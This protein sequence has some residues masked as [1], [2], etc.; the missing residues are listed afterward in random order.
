MIDEAIAQARR[1][2]GVDRR[3]PAA[4]PRRSRSCRDALGVDAG[5]QL[6]AIDGEDLTVRTLLAPGEWPAR[7][8]A[9][10]EQDRS[11]DQEHAARLRRRRAARRRRPDRAPICRSSAPTELEPRKSDRHKAYR[12]RSDPGSAERLTAEQERVCALLAR[13]RAVATRERTAALVTIA[14]EVIA[15]YRAEKER[16]GLLDY[17]DL[18]DKTLRLLGERSAAG[19]TTSSISASI[20]C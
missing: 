3:A 2:R 9:V 7:R 20:T 17:D 1:A 14:A 19:C 5:R 12:A 6:G 11:S 16:R 13:R 18:I 4:S 10:L 15:R 8:S